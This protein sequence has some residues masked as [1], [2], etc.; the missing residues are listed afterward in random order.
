MPYVCIFLRRES[1]RDLPAVPCP[2]EVMAEPDTRGSGNPPDRVISVTKRPREPLDPSHPIDGEDSNAEMSS[3]SETST[4]VSAS[5]SD[6]GARDAKRSRPERRKMKDK[7]KKSVAEVPDSSPVIPKQP[8]A[9]RWQR[10]LLDLPQ[11]VLLE[12]CAYLDSQ[13]QHA[14]RETCRLLD[15]ALNCS[16]RFWK[17]MCVKEEFTKYPCLFAE[18]ED[19]D[20]G[21]YRGL[22]M[23]VQPPSQFPRWK[24]F[25]AKGCQM[26]R[27]FWRGNVEA[28]RVF[29]N[30][31]LPVATYTPDVD[32]NHVRAQLGDF[33][34]MLESDD[35]K[36]AFSDKYMVAFHH[37]RNH[38]TTTL[39]HLWDISG[40]PTFIYRVDMNHCRVTENI[41]IFNDHVV[42]TPSLPLNAN[43]L[44]MTLDMGN[45]M[46]RAGSYIFPL[47]N[48]QNSLDD[49]WFHTQ[50][51]VV[52]NQALVTCR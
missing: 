8:E 3:H 35:I 7:G 39:I 21:G 17:M 18:D 20:K 32:L 6:R 16:E 31:N 27:N 25:F 34:K 22:R 47:Y 37:V 50:L 41:A 24:K 11:E 36:Y 5:A 2:C 43:A 51:R 38:G 45:Y 19:P 12:I 15:G 13:S 42:I 26:R 4:V 1:V 23:R 28:S 52:R 48:R 46:A 30:T 33:P 10:G 44:I 49:N 9:I 40:E 29:A 14:L